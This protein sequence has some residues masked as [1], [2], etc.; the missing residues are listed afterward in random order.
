MTYALRS[1]EYWAY[2][3]R[4]VWR[5]SVVTSIV[6]PILYLTAL[7]VGLGKLV[8]RGPGVGVPYLDFVAPGILA[9]TAMQLATFESSYPVMAAIRWTRQFHAMLA[10]PLRSRDLLIGHQL[11][12]AAR[13]AVVSA[14]YLVVLAGFGALHSPYAILAW[15]AA[16]L[17]GLAHSAPVSAFSAWLQREEGFNGLFR[18]V[19][20][21]MFLFSGTFFPVTRLPH[22]AR[23]IA[24]ATPLWNGVDLMRHLT[25]GTASLWPSLA[26]VAYLL[27][28]VAG[29]LTLAART[30]RRR[31]VT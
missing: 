26:H 2:S 19:V 17:V 1:F 31:L 23:E 11:Y 12:V 8:N 6:G 3:Y 20:M 10:T 22:G 13:L 30:Y 16:V 29:G 27:L 4:R 25:L 7:G 15:P 14:I 21:P 9:A 5:G 28:W 18:F 24:Y